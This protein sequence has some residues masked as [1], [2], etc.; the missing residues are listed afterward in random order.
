MIIAMPHAHTQ[1]ITLLL[2]LGRYPLLMRS[3]YGGRG[4][5]HGRS[6]ASILSK[7]ERAAGTGQILSSPAS[8][9]RIHWNLRGGSLVPPAANVVPQK[10]APLMEAPSQGLP[11]LSNFCVGP[12]L[13]LRLV[14]E[15]G[16]ASQ[17]VYLLSFLQGAC[18]HPRPLQR[19]LT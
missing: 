11:W 15:L 17:P 16:F 3:T 14:S 19:P 18:G 4:G 12:G 10:G 2:K 7:W 8:D 9:V 13:A 5:G 6:F 1:K